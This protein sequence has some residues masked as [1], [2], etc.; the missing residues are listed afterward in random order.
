MKYSLILLLCLGLL[1]CGN[2]GQGNQNGT[3]EG[4][5]ENVVETTTPEETPPEV[6]NLIE[7]KIWE[8][9]SYTYNGN[10]IPNYN[11]AEP[12]TLYLDWKKINGFAGCNNFNGKLNLG[13]GVISMSGISRTKKSC[14]SEMVH[15]FRF[16]ELL[17]AA[18][19]YEANLANLI[20]KSG[21]LGEL[22]FRIK[23]E[24]QE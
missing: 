11:F 1:A 20:I 18:E 17:E 5:N 10:T 6:R 12:I 23:S 21:E 9:H 3:D 15:E 16:L 2:D 14:P 22:R 19:T 8:L 7:L 4:T 13:E 24:N